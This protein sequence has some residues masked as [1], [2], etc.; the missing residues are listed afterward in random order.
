MMLRGKCFCL[1]SLQPSISLHRGDANWWQGNKNKPRMMNLLLMHLFPAVILKTLYRH[2]E[3]Q[4]PHC[5]WAWWV[6][7][8]VRC[9]GHVLAQSKGVLSALWHPPARDP[10]HIPQPAPVPLAA[11]AWHCVRKWGKMG[12]LASSHGRFLR[13]LWLGCDLRCP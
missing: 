10:N 4:S 2:P 8:T 1:L 13:N 11:R 7:H 3:A 9:R 5:S 6:Q 12:G